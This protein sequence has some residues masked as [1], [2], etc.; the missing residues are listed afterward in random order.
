MSFSGQITHKSKK[1]MIG[2]EKEISDIGDKEDI[3]N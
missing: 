1:K 2:N 3:Q